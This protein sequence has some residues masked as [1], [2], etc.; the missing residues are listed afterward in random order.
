MTF[1]KKI[2]FDFTVKELL[3]SLNKVY[4]MPIDKPIEIRMTNSKGEII[5]NIYDTFKLQFEIEEQK[6]EK[7]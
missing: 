3:N 5:L 2:I 4:G 6:E 7:E 1:V